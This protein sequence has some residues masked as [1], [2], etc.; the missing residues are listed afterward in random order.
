VPA[1]RGI[2]HVKLPVGEVGR[3]REWYE[4]VLGLEVEIE[5]VEDG[6][7]RGVALR[8]RDATLS[9]A[10]REEPEKAG[11]LRGFDPVS[12]AVGT[13]DD[14]RDWCAHLDALGESHGGV[15]TGHQGWV[16]VGLHDP[17]GLEVRLYTRERHDGGGS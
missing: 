2:H 9:I 10:L 15:Q 14:L 11:V 4:R 12:L 13:R 3:S 16:V 8:D 7:L 17:D 1:L 6:V 5:F